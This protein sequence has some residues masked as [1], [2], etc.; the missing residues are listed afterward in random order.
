MPYPATSGLSC[1][2]SPPFLK[3]KDRRAGLQVESATRTDT[4]CGGD[5]VR[6]GQRPGETCRSQVH[7]EDRGQGG[8]RRGDRPDFAAASSSGPWPSCSA[9]SRRRWPRATLVLPCSMAFVGTISL[10]HIFTAILTHQFFEV[11]PDPVH[12]FF[13][14]Q[15]AGLNEISGGQPGLAVP[16]VGPPPC[17]V[18]LR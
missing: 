3:A 11:L 10:R 12:H 17:G 18:G 8:R 2:R 7:S 1:S 14:G 15:G 5:A 13:R 16:P 6:R 4:S 9:G